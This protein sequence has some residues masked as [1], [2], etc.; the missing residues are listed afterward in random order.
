MSIDKIHQRENEHENRNERILN[1]FFAMQKK[2]AN[3][4]TRPSSQNYFINTYGKRV[5]HSKKD[6]R[7]AEIESCMPRS[8]FNNEVI[9][10]SQK[11]LYHDYQQQ[12][13]Q[14]P[15]PLPKVVTATKNVGVKDTDQ[16]LSRKMDVIFSNSALHW[17]QDHRK[18]F[19]NFWKMLKPMNSDNGTDMSIDSNS[20]NTSVSGQL[21]IQCGEYGNLQQIIT[22]LERITHLDQFREYL[23]DWKQPRYFAKDS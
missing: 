17:I 11:F 5:Y 19:Q 8:H 12:Q 9:S 13:N 6:E 21:L 16:P 1:P 20:N 18:A 10:R 23:A 2:M 15:E 22:M 7:V 3:A 14:Q 4:P